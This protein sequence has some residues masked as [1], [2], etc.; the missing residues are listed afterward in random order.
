MMAK[1]G[2]FGTLDP[3]KAGMR[4]AGNIWFG[5]TLNEKIANRKKKMRR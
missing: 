5:T 3:G 2:W 4:R 1:R